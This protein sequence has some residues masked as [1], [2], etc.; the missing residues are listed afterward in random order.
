MH[1]LPGDPC[2]AAP[3]T[4]PASLPDRGYA[5]LLDAHLRGCTFNQPLLTAAGALYVAEMIC[6]GK[7]DASPSE[8][9]PRPHWDAGR[10]LWLGKQLLK[11]FRQPAS[12]Q[13]TLLDAFEEQGWSVHIDDP[14]PRQDA[15]EEQDSKRRLH[16]TIRNLNRNLPPNTI[17]FRGDGTGQGVLWEYCSG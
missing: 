6:R 7:S 2:Q 1:H 12:N 3:S 10:R 8:G 4:A 16:D 14:L 9:R 13:T 17:R 11:W 15:E 5:D